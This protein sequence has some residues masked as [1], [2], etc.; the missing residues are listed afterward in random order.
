MPPHHRLCVL[1]IYF[2][3]TC[4]Y[5][6]LGSIQYFL[7]NR[8]DW[9]LPVKSTLI[10]CNCLSRCGFMVHGYAT[11]KV[12]FFIIYYQH[13]SIQLFAYAYSMY[14]TESMPYYNTCG[15][16]HAAGKPRSPP[17][18]Q[19]CFPCSSSVVRGTSRMYIKLY[20]SYLTCSSTW[21][22][23]WASAPRFWV[24]INLP[25]WKTGLSLGSIARLHV[26]EVYNGK[27]TQE[28]GEQN[29]PNWNKA[30]REMEKVQCLCMEKP[31]CVSCK[32]SGLKLIWIQRKELQHRAELQEG[33][34]EEEDRAKDT[35]KVAVIVWAH[36]LGVCVYITTAL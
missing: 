22:M 25:I 31:F 14:Q 29:G 5:V 27:E 15:W 24:N 17:C 7:F 23:G 2:I 18:S 28:E 21:R 3:F 35:S 1:F 6:V 11:G 8:C 19:Q 13:M 33:E 9:F 10:I 12:T 36:L 26:R 30:W 34:G 4:F 16:M 32:W 20:L